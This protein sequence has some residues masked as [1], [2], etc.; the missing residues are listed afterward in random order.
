MRKLILLFCILSS[1]ITILHAQDNI[2][3]DSALIYIYRGG[4]M[5]GA[6]SN[7]AIFL[8]GQKV[9]KISNNRY[10]VLTV[11]P[12]KHTVSAHI[13]G[14]DLFK[15][16]TNIELETEGGKAFYVSCSIKQSFT[17]A[18]LEMEEVTKSTA[19]K[20]LE[21]MQLDKCQ[22]KIDEKE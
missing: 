6:L 2:S 16:E 3:P 1:S 14:A 18:R 22:E 20:H 8:D 4:Q 21:K 12:G 11:K 13:G 15:K 17:R 5:N 9:C 7:W 19:N 10:M